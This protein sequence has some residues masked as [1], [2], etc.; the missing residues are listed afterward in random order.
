MG[1][2]DFSGDSMGPYYE[3][4]ERM[5]QVTPA[6]MDLTGGVGRVIARGAE[7]MG[8]SH[9]PLNRNAPDCDGQGVCCFGCPTGA[10][11]STDVS[12]VPEA[13]MRGAQLV[14]AA[15]VDG[16]EVVAGRARGVR[17]SLGGS[18][19]GKRFTVKADAV[20]IAGGALM[21]P[22]LLKKSKLLKSPALGK[23]LS[24]HPATKVMALFD[25]TI[26]MASAIPQGYAIDSLMN[27]GIVFEGASTPLDVTA[28][29]VPW[30]GKKY[31]EVMEGFRHL[32]TF[33]LMIRDSSRGAVRPGP[34]GS[35]LITYNLN[36][37]D[38]AKLQRGLALLC[39]VFLAA[40]A[41]RIL[42]FIAGA[43]EVRGPLDIAR[44]RSR[45]LAPMDVEVTA[46]H[47]LGTA[48]VGTDVKTSVLKPDHETHEIQ[49]LYVTD[50]SAIPSSLGVN[51][52]M[53]IMAMALR[54]AEIIDTRLS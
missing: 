28:I 4:V 46:F 30:V 13:L 10:K 39:E 27:E 43:E 41:K 6:K 16:I 14:T 7:K 23:N 25:E 40:G 9:H 26:D 33:G 48:R 37:R 52:Q 19:S 22:V 11:R 3:R 49:S 17:G 44:L 24:I 5:L 35:P 51:P 20:V 45:R 1:L 12:Y 32:A 50:G 18:A 15:H 36:A 29:A 53:T 47:P 38:S 8:L 34:N 42:P 2:T 54:A 31:M 21:T